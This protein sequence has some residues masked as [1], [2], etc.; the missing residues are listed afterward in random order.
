ML[1]LTWLKSDNLKMEA[2]GCSKTLLPT[3]TTETTECH[4][5]D[6]HNTIIQGHEPWTSHSS[7]CLSSLRHKH[8]DFKSWILLQASTYPLM[9]PTSGPI[10]FGQHWPVLF[11]VRRAA[12]TPGRR[13][14]ASSCSACVSAYLPVASATIKSSLLVNGTRQA[15]T[16]HCLPSTPHTPPAG[17]PRGVLMNSIWIYHR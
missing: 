6:D 17:A 7:Y 8:A 5:Q 1:R 10:Y 2:A 12:Q 14:T 3:E 13:P 16:L 4:I 15:H 11:V 9:A